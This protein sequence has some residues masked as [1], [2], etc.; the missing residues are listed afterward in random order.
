[1]IKIP[2]KVLNN[3]RAMK[4]KTKFMDKKR[5]LGPLDYDPNDIEESWYPYIETNEDIEREFSF[6]DLMAEEFFLYIPLSNI[7]IFYNKNL[8][9]FLFKKRIFTITGTK[10][11]KS[12]IK[13][14][15]ESC[16]KRLSK[17]EKFEE[18]P[19]IPF[20]DTKKKMDSDFYKK[21]VLGYIKTFFRASPRNANHLKRIKKRPTYLMKEITDHD[22]SEIEK[23]INR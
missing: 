7:T 8:S 22:Y 16:N 3:F 21:A 12:V 11:Q 6:D 1:M 13:R 14:Y 10:D 20:N 19:S 23:W 17:L 15:I 5:K 4:L 2:S 18:S 9:K